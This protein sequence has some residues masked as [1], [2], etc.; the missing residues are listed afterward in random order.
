MK[1]SHDIE[2]SEAPHENIAFSRD[3]Q[4]SRGGLWLA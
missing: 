2:D 3:K 1:K 4:F